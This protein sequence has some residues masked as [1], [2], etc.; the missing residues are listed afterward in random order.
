MARLHGQ[1]LSGR[2]QDLELHG[3]RLHGGPD[4]RAGAQAVRQ[5]AYARERNEA[6][7]EPEESAPADLAA[8][9]QDEHQRQGL[10]PDQADA[11]GEVQRG[12]LG[13]VRA[14]DE[15]RSGELIREIREH[16]VAGRKP[17]HFFQS[18]CGLIQYAAAKMANPIAAGNSASH[19][20]PTATAAVAAQE[21][22]ENASANVAKRE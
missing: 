5:R 13:A 16:K 6:R 17:G 3:V 15:R 8:E 11:H 9:Y 12:A 20:P 18:R 4:A 10:L 2:R 1:V 14:G 22:D 19:E 21:I 7:G